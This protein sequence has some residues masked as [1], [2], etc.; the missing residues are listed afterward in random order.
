MPTIVVHHASDGPDFYRNKQHDGWPAEARVGWLEVLERGNVVAI[1]TGH[2]HR[3]ELWWNELGIP[4]Y[5]AAPIA[6]YW[7]RQGAIRI[8]T[9][10]KGRLSYQTVY[11]EKSP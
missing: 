10:S 7:G 3:D 1:I 5:T 11:M 2:F 9:Y 6:G 8:Y 4:V